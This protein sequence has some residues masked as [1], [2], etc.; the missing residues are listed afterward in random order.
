MK[1]LINTDELNLLATAIRENEGTINESILWAITY[2]LPLVLWRIESPIQLVNA[3][4]IACFNGT[5]KS[6]SNILGLERS[7]AIGSPLLQAQT[8]WDTDGKVAAEQPPH[9]PFATSVSDDDEPI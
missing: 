7:L 4:L 9:P 3:L 6:I 1:Q 5:D 8:G 2:H